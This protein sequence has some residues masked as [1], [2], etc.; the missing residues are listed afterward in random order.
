MVNCYTCYRC[1][2]LGYKIYC[3]FFELE[4]CHR[5]RHRIVIPTDMDCPECR[6]RK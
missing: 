3:P 1:Q 6:E 2:K 5:G 4:E